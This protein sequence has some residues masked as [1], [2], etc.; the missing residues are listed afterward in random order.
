MK[1][2][3]P[4]WANPEHLQ[5]KPDSGAFGFYDERG[6]ATAVASMSELLIALRDSR[7]GIRFVWTPD[8]DRVRIPEEL[9]ELDDVLWQRAKKRAARDCSDG[10]R[11]GLVFSIVVGWTVLWGWQRFQGNLEAVV[12]YPSL[13]ISL[14]LFFM[15][16]F[17]PWYEGRKVLRKGC[18]SDEERS[19]TVAE[20]RFEIWMDKQ[21]VLFTRCLLLLLGAVGA[22]QLWVS[23]G[24]GADS[25]TG[26]MLKPD[27]D[28][29]RFATAGFLHGN[30]LHWVMNV[31]ALL[32]LAKR[33]EVLARWPHLLAVFSVSMLS[34][35]LAS[36]WWNSEQPTV[37][38]SG[39]ILGLLGFLLV[40][41]SMHQ[42]LVPKSARKRLLAGLGVIALMGL[43]G[44]SFI[45]NGAH[46]GGLV[47]GALYALLFFS[48]TEAVVRSKVTFVLSVIGGL[49]GLVLAVAAAFS[50]WRVL[51]L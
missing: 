15:F 4:N 38:A 18:L 47:A 42:R 45:D 21:P 35:G 17:L 29:W 25:I 6:E 13:G 16:G 34:G 24:Q 46:I 1:Q 11:W 22:A 36:V 12:S 14:V 26:G 49:A 40:F 2:K 3:A 33:V 7:H 31:S 48:R 37:G 8:S 41:E 23:Y 5:E 43:L 19:D 50:V 20:V 28:W 44:F 27:L 10:L 30:V 39:A 32:F 9:V 51:G